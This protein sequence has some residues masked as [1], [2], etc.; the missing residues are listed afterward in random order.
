MSLFFF[1]IANQVGLLRRVLVR[2][3][4]INF[5]EILLCNPCCYVRTD[6]R[7]DMT[8]PTL[9]TTVKL[10]MTLFNNKFAAGFGLTLKSFHKLSSEVV[11]YWDV[12]KPAS[13]S[14]VRVESSC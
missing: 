13:E 3:P 5:Q 12:M 2:I 6:G 14:S 9:S 11:V 1:T 10:S 8:Q 4:D 7:T